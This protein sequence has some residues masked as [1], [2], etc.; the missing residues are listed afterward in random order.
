[1]LSAKRQIDYMI[2]QTLHEFTRVELRNKTQKKKRQKGH[3]L[4]E[5]SGV[6]QR[7]SGS[8]NE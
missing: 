1:M 7:G 3:T 2:S 4:G 6:Y 8:A 5:K